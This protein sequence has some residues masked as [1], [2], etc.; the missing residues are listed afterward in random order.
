MEIAFANAEK[1]NTEFHQ[2]SCLKCRVL[3][4]LALTLLPVLSASPPSDA[5]TP[6]QE[7]ALRI[8]KTIKDGYERCNPPRDHLIRGRIFYVQRAPEG[9]TIAEEYRDDPDWL[10]F[11][12]VQKGDCWRYEEQD[13]RKPSRMLIRL[14]DG[15]D[16]FRSDD[17]S[18]APNTN[19]DRMSLLLDYGR[20]FCL[21]WGENWNFYNVSVAMDTLSKMIQST[22][23]QAPEYRFDVKKENG[24]YRVA[25]DSKGGE[26]TVFIDP[27]QGF[28]MVRQENTIF[29]KRGWST[30]SSMTV[31]FKEV[32]P[33]FWL[34]RWGELRSIDPDCIM[35]CVLVAEDVRVD[36]FDYDSA[37]FTPASIHPDAPDVSP[38]V[39]YDRSRQ[40][41]MVGQS[42]PEL[43]VATWVNGEPVTLAS[44]R[45]K[46]VVVAFCDSADESSSKLVPALNSLVQKYSRSGVEVVAVHGSDGNV[47]ALKQR[48]SED[49]IEFRVAIDK[50]ASPKTQKGATFKKYRVR[51]PPS[52]F[53]IDADGKIRYQDVALRA[54]EETVKELL[55]EGGSVV[56]TGVSVGSMASDPSSQNRGLKTTIEDA[57]R[58]KYEHLES[59]ALHYSEESVRV[60]AE[61]SAVVSLVEVL[62]RGDDKAVRESALAPS[63]GG[64]SDVVAV[65]TGGVYRRLFFSR[66]DG[67]CRGHVRKESA[68]F[69]FETL[70]VTPLG[71]SMLDNMRW[72]KDKVLHPNGANNDMTVLMNLPDSRV[73]P[74]TAHV[75]GHECYV[76]ERGPQEHPWT[77][78]Y[79]GKDVGLAV[80]KVEAYAREGSSRFLGFSVTFGDF[81]QAAPGLYMP[82]EG[83]QTSYGVDGAV[84]SRRRWYDISLNLAPDIPKDAFVLDFP[85]GTEVTDEDTR[86]EY[87]SDHG[88]LVPPR[89][90]RSEP[91]VGRKAPELDV[92]EWVRGEPVKLAS[93]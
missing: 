51:T 72:P 37:L 23:P 57:Y 70:G 4:G 39:E 81:A 82:R 80:C 33:G 13:S 8:L 34:P 43:D 76:I 2:L 24:L 7:Q 55:K 85:D 38:Y 32:K 45:G 65:A 89:E 21:F 58:R 71:Y 61:S 79:L 56:A 88:Q 59:Y 16:C 75:D 15:L 91:M 22:D 66:E 87:I 69:K 36:E 52:L 92:A 47:A 46:V 3:F 77:K 20:F 18:R 17:K 28:N 93:P 49:S 5:L 14:C 41:T 84:H 73:L 67:T 35:E 68:A 26:V 44:L 31:K 30:T 1:R 54:L 9:G 42:A 78:W 12:Y 27:G 53:V 48:V 60:G 6:E 90:Y 86:K 19:A 10:H 62:T 63:T 25:W 40:P 74:E 50:P 64:R 11:Q 29:W 83:E